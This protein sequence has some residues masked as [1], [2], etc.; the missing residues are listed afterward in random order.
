MNEIEECAINIKLNGYH[1]FRGLISDEEIEQI[2]TSA[3]S[4]RREY[5]EEKVKQRLFYRRESSHNRQGDALMVSNSET[6]L[7]SIN[8]QNT[9][10]NKY[11]KMYN[12]IIEEC[13]GQK[14]TDS[15]Q[16]RSM[17]NIQEYFSG[18]LPVYN[19]YDGE[20]FFFFHEFD[21]NTNE[22]ILKLDK[23][24]IPRFVMVCVLE[25]E[26]DG[27]GVYVCKHDSHD[28]ID[29]KLYPGDVLVF[30]NVNLR[31]GVPELD[32]PRMMIGLRNFD[33][34]P[35][36][37]EASPEENSSYKELYDVRNPGWVK[38]LSNEETQQIQ[39]K[40]NKIWYE[41]GYDKNVRTSKP[42]F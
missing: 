15:S 9:P 40:Y 20:F 31:H 26:N 35:Y 2:K 34:N 1:I 42:A 39:I 6:T 24:L 22:N 8:I 17:L 32:K 10:I 23:A 33:Y 13:V 41:K 12:N 11:F 16:M 5:S 4:L 30:D 27:K 37:F 38:E 18:S 29:V 3:F 28:R 25:N 36:Y 14:F 21:S 7:P 19:H